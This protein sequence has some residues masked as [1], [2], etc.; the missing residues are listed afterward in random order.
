MSW[1][2]RRGP[3][4][5][6]VFLSGT[7]GLFCRALLTVALFRCAPQRE[8]SFGADELETK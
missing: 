5:V 7:C 1:S 4:A 2:P 3:H 6:M 8:L